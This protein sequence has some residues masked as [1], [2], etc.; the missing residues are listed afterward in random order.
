MAPDAERVS[1]K[2]V[3]PGAAYAL[4]RVIGQRVLVRAG[5][6]HAVAA[7][8]YDTALHQLGNDRRRRG[9]ARDPETAHRTYMPRAAGSHL[10]QQVDRMRR[11]PEQKLRAGL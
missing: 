2:T 5:F 3:P 11:Y 6:G 1:G 8:R 4:G 10:A 7:L 9:G